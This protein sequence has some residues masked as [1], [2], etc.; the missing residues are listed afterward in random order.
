[1]TTAAGAQLR[2]ASWLLTEEA[3]RNY[4]GCAPALGREL[5]D[6]EHSEP[7]DPNGG[8]GLV[9]FLPVLSRGFRAFRNL[10]VD[11]SY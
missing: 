8:T 3:N 6:L 2:S 9:G 5:T 4:A 11:S 10:P 7:G 1:M